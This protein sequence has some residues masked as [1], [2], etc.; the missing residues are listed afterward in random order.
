MVFGCGGQI[1]Y[2]QNSS[3]K[4]KVPSD[5]V[6]C[7]YCGGRE[8]TAHESASSNDADT[9]EISIENFQKIIEST[10]AIK[11]KNVQSR[12]SK[13][14]LSSRFEVR[15]NSIGR[16]LP[17]AK[18]KEWQPGQAARKRN[19]FIA[20][21]VGVIALAFIFQVKSNSTSSIKS[22]AVKVLPGSDAY[23][24]GYEA[25]RSFRSNINYNDEFINQWIPD[26]RKMLDELGQSSEN[27][28]KDMVG[29]IADDAWASAALEA[30]IMENSPANR[31]D[32]RRGMIDGYFN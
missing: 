11:E 6:F 31:A 28:T 24:I 29:Q 30:G 4:K 1:M 15:M 23:K 2:C 8:F 7:P 25:G 20:I 12:N 9:S 22:T 16:K 10:E 17:S 18:K 27:M 5:S 14:S 21:F 19:F 3:C 26:V 32:F 13:P